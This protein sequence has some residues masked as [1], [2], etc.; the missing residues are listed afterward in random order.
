M[1]KNTIDDAKKE[2][3]DLKS[4]L[5]IKEAVGKLSGH[6]VYLAI[7]E[8]SADWFTAKNLS[9]LLQR[10]QSCEI[11]P[12][13]DDM[14]EILKL[15]KD[16]IEDLYF[17]NIS[18]Q[19]LELTSSPSNIQFDC[20]KELLSFIITNINL[21]EKYDLEWNDDV[22][23]KIN[24]RKCTD[25]T[26]LLNTWNSS[27]STKNKPVDIIGTLDHIKVDKDKISYTDMKGLLDTLSEEQKSQF[28][29][30]KAICCI[31]D[32]LADD[33]EAI[34]MSE[35]AK[36]LKDYLTEQD[37]TTILNKTSTG[38]VKDIYELVTR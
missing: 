12:E 4:F 7:K 31:L 1:D 8:I 9:E 5:N 38:G 29:N 22:L 32:K 25:I 35:L 24:D 23:N 16:N 10:I 33:N 27:G 2:L 13:A 15:F 34:N 19:I 18:K 36:Q 30:H 28:K 26:T 11:A 6:D 20:F 14:L 21:E 37:T 17:N 3:A